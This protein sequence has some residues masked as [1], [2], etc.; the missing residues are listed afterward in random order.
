MHSLCAVL[1]CSL[2][3][4]AAACGS[5]APD[6]N[7]HL[8]ATQELTALEHEV[9]EAATRSDLTVMERVLADDFVGIEANGQQLSRA[10]V[11]DRFHIPDFQVLTLRHEE[12]RVH[13]FGDCAVTTATTVLEARYKGQQIR[14]RFPYTRVWLKR[15]SGWRAVFTQSTPSPAPAAPATT[16]LA[17]SSESR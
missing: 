7:G 1:G 5:N 8:K 15:A 4:A 14:G 6:R 16:P 9:A 12:I 10:Q 11:L 17:G 2:L 13:A 3:V